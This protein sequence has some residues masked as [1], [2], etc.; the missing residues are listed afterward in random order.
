MD[1]AICL[2]IEIKWLCGFI[3]CD[4]ENAWDTL[5]EIDIT[6]L[7]ATAYLPQQDVWRSFKK[8]DAGE[9]CALVAEATNVI[10]FNGK[11]WDLPFLGKFAA[12][13][14]ARAKLQSLCQK[15]TSN[16]HDDIYQ[17]ATEIAGNQSIK[18]YHLARLNFGSKAM[19]EWRLGSEQYQSK[20]VKE[21]WE[22][23]LA[24]QASKAWEDVSTT[25][26]LWS[27]WRENKLQTKD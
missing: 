7:A 20:L 5:S 1:S 15:V 16:S 18:R 19:D 21:G 9:L 22:N 27:L 14:S 3:M 8:D 13:L 4:Y 17:I 10:T 24:F 11:K 26:A 2:D 23:V 6:F 12:T 25:Y